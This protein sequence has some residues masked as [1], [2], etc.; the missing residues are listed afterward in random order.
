MIN[1]TEIEKM[2]KGWKKD[3]L[4]NLCKKI[5]S[6]GTPDTR[7]PEYWGGELNWLSSGET[8]N[9]FIKNTEKA[10]TQEGVK[11][12]STRLA[13]KNDLVMACAGQGHTRGQVSICLI[14]TYVNQSIITMRT[15]QKALS[16]YFLFYYLSSKYQFLRDLSASNS[17]RGSITCP[18]LGNLDIIHPEIDEQ[19]KIASILTNYDNLIQNNT[20]KI[21]LLE[22]IA[23]LI[24]EEWFV[25]FKFP[26]HE[27]VKFVDSELGKI[28]EGWEVKGIIDAEYFDLIRENIKSFDNK[29]TYFATADIKGIE[30]VKDGINY[31]YKNKPSRAQKQPVKYSVWFARM[32]DTYKVI[33][34]T[35]V[36]EPLAN[37]CMISSGFAGFK[38]S[39]DLFPFLYY[40]INSIYF[41]KEKDRFA[42]GATQVSLNNESLSKIKI[43]KPKEEIINS[44]GN[45]VLSIINEIFLLQQKNQNLS[46]TR[47]L[48]LPR[49]ITGKVDVSELDIQVEVEA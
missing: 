13:L 34:F 49:L 47:D 17:I 30:F 43:I 9:K 44:Y 16:Q 18:M 14:D 4:K 26:G 29:K 6:G 36:N 10:I 31:F 27:K 20:K 15:N 1:L 23:K 8:R 41:H 32:K 37:N 5:F 24:Y 40:T 38:C 28:P 3:K 46:K 19:Q 21:N 25:K 33:G 42:T 35:E 2:N 11:N 39:K 22:K 48:L 45:I 7:K 12:S